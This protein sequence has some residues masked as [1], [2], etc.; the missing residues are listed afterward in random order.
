MS[1][2]DGKSGL[3][4]DIGVSDAGRSRR[5][6]VHRAGLR[7]PSM[8][9]TAESRPRSCRGCY[10][11]FVRC[12]DCSHT[13]IAYNRCRNRHCPSAA[14]APDDRVIQIDARCR[15]GRRDELRRNLGR[16]TEA[17]SSRIDR[18]S[19]CVNSMPSGSVME[20]LPISGS[21][22]VPTFSRSP[23]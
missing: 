7:K 9:E 11:G 10:G 3:I 17:A 13:Q 2:I 22:A 6:G 20:G 18:Y 19:S 4:A 5:C 23:P 14:R 21:W 8:S 16:S 15:I 1:A 12:E